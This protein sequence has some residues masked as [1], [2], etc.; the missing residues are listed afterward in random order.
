MISRS[1]PGYSVDEMR[2]NSQH[3]DITIKTCE[4]HEIGKLNEYQIGGVIGLSVLSFL[5]IGSGDLVAGSVGLIAVLVLL[6]VFRYFAKSRQ[7]IYN[8]S[9]S[10]V[11][12]MNQSYSVAIPWSEI[13][14]IEFF[15]G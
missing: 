5:F 6:L 4:D 15:H 3:L 2:V 1:V 14:S 8:V 13:T 11:S 12:V 9:D 7:S 10:G